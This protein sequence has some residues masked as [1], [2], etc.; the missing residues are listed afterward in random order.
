MRSENVKKGVSRL[1]HRSLFKAL[2]YTDVELK[3]PLI[4]IVNSAN[5]LIPGHM[6]LNSIVEAAKEGVLMSGGMVQQFSTI[7]ICDGVAMNHTGMKYSLASREIIADSIE[8]VV[9]AHGFDGLVFVPN[10]DKIVPGMIMAALRLNI[11]SIVISGGPMLAGRIK[12]R[13]IDLSTCFEAVAEYKAGKYSAMIL[14]YLK[15]KHA[16]PA[17][18]VPVCLQQIL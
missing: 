3:K 4:G 5:T 2:G 14:K 6:N 11:P 16:R 18:A 8:A 9:M 13:A 7:G 10:C 17:E 12:D 1:P 15:K